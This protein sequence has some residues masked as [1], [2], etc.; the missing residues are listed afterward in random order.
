MSDESKQIMRSAQCARIIS[1]IS[2]MSNISLDEATDIYYN[3][4]TANLIEKGVADLHCRSDKYLA[5]EIL[6]EIQNQSNNK[7]LG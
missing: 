6:R 1:C 7:L 2:E 4:E 3:S 5:E